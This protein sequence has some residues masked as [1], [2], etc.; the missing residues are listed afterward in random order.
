[1]KKNLTFLA[2]LIFLA[3][4]L[5]AQR[6][7]MQK[8]TEAT[9]GSH[10]NELHK[11]FKERYG[12]VYEEFVK[13]HEQEKPGIPIQ[14]TRKDIEKMTKAIRD[15]RINDMKKKY[16]EINEEEIN[17]NPPAQHSTKGNVWFRD[18]LYRYSGNGNDWNLQYRDIVLARDADGNKTEEYRQQRNNQT[19]E[20]INDYKYMITIKTETKRN[21]LIRTGITV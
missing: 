17:T 20:W 6:D 7:D 14:F 16:H 21:I 19:N 15:K 10:S 5:F 13:K 11:M 2:V 8:R 3:T 9:V 12:K 1:M 4:A 18:S